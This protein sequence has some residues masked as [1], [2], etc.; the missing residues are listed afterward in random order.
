MPTPCPRFPPAK[1]ALPVP[2]PATEAAL[3]IWAKSTGS[4]ARRPGHN[5]VTSQLWSP[6]CAALGKSLNLSVSHLSNASGDQTGE[7]NQIGPI[8][9]VLGRSREVWWVVPGGQAIGYPR[10]LGIRARPG[11]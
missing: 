1:W 9:G 2:F 4:G 3:G 6:I 7:M 10:T 11:P 5:L 8:L